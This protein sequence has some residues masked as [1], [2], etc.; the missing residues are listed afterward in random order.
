MQ[1]RHAEL[2]GTK[3]MRVSLKRGR[4]GQALPTAFDQSLAPER[5][6]DLVMAAR[7]NVKSVKR[8]LTRGKRQSGVTTVSGSHWQRCTNGVRVSLFKSSEVATA[9]ERLLRHEG[10]NKL[11]SERK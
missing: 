2:S 7:P 1:M 8:L 9:H 10:F 11:H 4:A 6:F 3:S 5:S